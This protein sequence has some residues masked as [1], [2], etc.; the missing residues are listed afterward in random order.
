MA[1]GETKI[2][3]S[4]GQTLSVYTD[5]SPVGSPLHCDIIG[6]AGATS[7]MN[8]VL[9]SPARIR[10]IQVTT[11]SAGLVEFYANGQRTY[12]QIPTDQRWL[13]TQAGRASYVP[14]NWTFRPGIKYS[15]L[16]VVQTS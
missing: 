16:P 11:T 1:A 4:N 10:D 8:F 7:P 9:Q 13:V 12:K 2:F 5:A 3:F 15:L 6:V 14:R